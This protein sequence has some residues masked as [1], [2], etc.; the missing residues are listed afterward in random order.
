MSVT[1]CLNFQ[2]SCAQAIELYKKAF[3]AIEVSRILYDEVPNELLPNFDPRLKGLVYECVLN[4]DGGEIKL[5]D[6]IMDRHSLAFNTMSA[7]VRLKGKERVHNAFKLLKDGGWQVTGEHMTGERANSAE[8]IDRFGVRWLIETEEAPSL[9]VS[10]ATSYETPY[11]EDIII[12]ST[13]A[14][15]RENDAAR[16]Q[17]AQIFSRKLARDVESGEAKGAVMYY[18]GESVGTYVYAAG[19][20]NKYAEIHAF[21]LLPK[22]W[23]RGAGRFMMDN[24]VARLAREGFDRARLWAPSNDMQA[25]F[26]FDDCGFSLSGEVRS[27]RPGYDEVR[28]ELIFKDY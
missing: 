20:L 6:R 15:C 19:R 16:R 18:D 17:W 25:R 27:P 24:L 5:S 23:R 1:F 10:P 7:L 21:Y 4:I 12:A 8:V 14:A 11:I 9:T 2:G 22:L 26:F 13:V 28:Y 3:D